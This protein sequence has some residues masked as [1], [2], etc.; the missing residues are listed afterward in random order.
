MRGEGENKRE[1]EGGEG[2]EK[3]M[4]VKRKWSSEREDANDKKVGEWRKRKRAKCLRS[5]GKQ[6]EIENSHSS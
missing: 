4:D 3:Q 1:V 5:T 6:A 2:K